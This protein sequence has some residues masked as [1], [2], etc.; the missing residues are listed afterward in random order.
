MG[1]PGGGERDPQH[2]LDAGLADRAV[3]A[4]MRARVRARA[5]TPRR[6]IARSVSSTAK[7]APSAANSAARGRVTTQAPA[8]AAKARPT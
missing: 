2:F 5:A 7:T 3:T 4:T 8:P 1:R 6:S